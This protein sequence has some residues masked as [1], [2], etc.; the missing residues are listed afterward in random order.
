M[1]VSHLVLFLKPRFTGRA[2]SHRADAEILR[3][4]CEISINF[5]LF[6]LTWVDFASWAVKVVG[7]H[8][9]WS[10]DGTCHTQHT[11]DALLQAVLTFLNNSL[12]WRHH[13]II[14]KL[15]CVHVRISS[16]LHPEA[17]HLALVCNRSD[18]KFTLPSNGTTDSTR[19]CESH[20][21][22]F[23]L[24]QGQNQDDSDSIITSAALSS[25][26]WRRSSFSSTMRLGPR[27]EGRSRRPG[28]NGHGPCNASFR[29]VG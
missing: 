25:G 29:I 3:R 12:S 22:S 6:G 19:F 16:A 20:I 21:P 11:F 1:V 18:A 17:L 2:W 14:S 4:E 26:T 5:I 24:Q 7:L 10:F 15:D 23:L 13:I 27:G 9:T 28:W 8:W